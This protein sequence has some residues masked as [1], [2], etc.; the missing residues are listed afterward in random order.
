MCENAGHGIRGC[1]INCIYP[2][3]FLHFGDGLDKDGSELIANAS[4][5]EAKERD[6]KY[7]IKDA[8]DLPSLCAGSDVA[9]SCRKKKLR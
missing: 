4:Q 9:I 3:H 2:E 7:C 8:E 5:Q 6:A 1:C